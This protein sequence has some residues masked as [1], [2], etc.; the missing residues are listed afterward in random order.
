M[1]QWLTSIL[2]D[3]IYKGVATIASILVED[4]YLAKIYCK[5]WSC[6]AAVSHSNHITLEMEIESSTSILSEL[7]LLDYQFSCI[8]IK[9][10]TSRDNSTNNN[11]KCKLST[12][13]AGDNV[14]FTDKTNT[15]Q[16]AVSPS[17]WAHQHGT[18]CPSA[19]FGYTQT[20]KGTHSKN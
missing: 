12:F 11:I 3:K 9:T 15:P 7:R 20:Q 16:S 10:N 19:K 6:N 1:F 17:F 2:D 8:C 4:Y 13:C 18:S 14:Y 5:V